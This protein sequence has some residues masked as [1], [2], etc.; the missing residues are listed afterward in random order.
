MVLDLIPH[1]LESRR[2][3]PAA[4]PLL[5]GYVSWSFLWRLFDIFESDLFENISEL[6]KILGETHPSID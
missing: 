2:D 3:F 4:F 1:P 6:S 5:V